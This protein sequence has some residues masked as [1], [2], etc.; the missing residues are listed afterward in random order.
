[1]GPAALVALHGLEEGSVGL[2]ALQRCS[3]QRL[4]TAGK[5]Q[6]VPLRAGGREVT[7]RHAARLAGALDDRGGVAVG[8]GGFHQHPPFGLRR[9]FCRRTRGKA[10]AQRQRQ[11]RNNTRHGRPV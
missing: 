11:K 4:V 10:S 2:Q 1:M 5:A 3:A 7:H 8:L 6:A 9:L